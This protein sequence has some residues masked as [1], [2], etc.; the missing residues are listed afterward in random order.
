M[1]TIPA[2]HFNL[3]SLPRGAR[4]RLRLTFDTPS[5][6]LGF[7]L[8]VARGANPGPVLL[9]SAGV[10]GDEYE[11]VQ[12][13]FDTWKMLEPA[14][15][16][17][18]FIAVPALNEPALRNR[19]RTSPLDEMNLARVFPGNPNGTPS[20]ALAWYFD[21][22]VLACATLY[23]D[24][25]SAGVLCEMPALAGYDASDTR[26]LDAATVFGAPVL[27]GHP[28]IPAGRTVSAAKA[29]DIPAIYVEARGAGRIHPAD[30]EVYRRGL[31]N[32]LHYLGILSGAPEPCAAELHLFGDGNIDES[33]TASADGF[34]VPAVTILQPVEPGE[35]LGQLLDFS[36]ELIEDYRA[37]RAGRVALIHACPLTHAGEPVFLVTGALATARP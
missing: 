34:L 12:A 28:N 18:D 14:A 35:L 32:L 13:I 19:T 1:T 33:I 30:L 26:S 8:L 3:A 17:G 16:Q 5:R 21:Q 6:Q 2:A 37:S 29:R 11:G 23:V 24:L 22:Y 7:N 31:R 4:H 10:H 20:E 15:M 36:G 25:H 27:W 9:V